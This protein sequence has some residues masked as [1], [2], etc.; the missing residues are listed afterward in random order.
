MI[1]IVKTLLSQGEATN[2]IEFRTVDNAGLVWRCD[3]SQKELE[4]NEYKIPLAGCTIDNSDK[5]ISALNQGNFCIYIENPDAFAPASKCDENQLSLEAFVHKEDNDLQ[6]S[7]KRFSPNGGWWICET[8]LTISQ[9]ESITENSYD[10]ASA[11]VS[12]WDLK[13]SQN[14]EICINTANMSSKLS[15]FKTYEQYY[16]VEE[17]IE[18]KSSDEN[19]LS[20]K[21]LWKPIVV[22]SA[23]VVAS[24]AFGLF[25]P[26]VKS[27]LI[28]FAVLLG[29]DL[30][31][32]LLDFG[33]KEEDATDRKELE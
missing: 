3:A 33:K 11:E 10:F 29:M 20:L 7:I 2:V 8:P 19:K 25:V 31:G 5:K 14:L 22:F 1:V 6:V 17:N 26:V 24:I 28:F 15:E 30:A 32:V 12:A 16:H 18:A 4:C 21:D 23:G 13:D 9:L 27:V